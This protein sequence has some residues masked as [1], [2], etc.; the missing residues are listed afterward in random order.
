MR[1][2]EYLLRRYVSLKFSFELRARFLLRQGGEGLHG[3]SLFPSM[4]REYSRHDSAE[5]SLAEQLFG[6]R[7]SLGINRH[8]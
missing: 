3:H 5:R 8:G 6:E 7:K 4:R 2:V 1:A